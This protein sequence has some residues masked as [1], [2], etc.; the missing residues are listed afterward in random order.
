MVTSKILWQLCINIYGFPNF[1]RLPKLGTDEKFTKQITRFDP[2]EK[3]YL[4]QPI[5]FNWG[6]KQIQFPKY[7]VLFGIPYDLP[8]SKIR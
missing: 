3:A 7:A 6:N 5:T 4:N 2:A 1:V 8:N